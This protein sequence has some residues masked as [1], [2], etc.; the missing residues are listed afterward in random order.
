MYVYW[1]FSFLNIA[2]DELF[3][4]FCLS[5]LSGLGLRANQISF[6]LGGTTLVYFLLQYALLTG[7]VDRLGLYRTLRVGTFG[8]VPLAIWIPIG[9]LWL[10]SRMN[11]ND[12]KAFDEGGANGTEIQTT[13]TPL[14]VV[15]LCTLIA[16]MKSLSSVV[17]STVTIGTNRTVDTIDQRATL[18]G[19][20]SLGGSFAKACGPVFAGTLFSFTAGGGASRGAADD[21]DA[22]VNNHAIERPYGS[23][24][25]YAILSFLG[26]LLGVQTLFLR[27]S[28]S[29]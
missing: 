15:Y 28:K 7:L 9:S 17:F 22:F 21:A 4:L 29:S 20:G 23:I 12:D 27:G 19:I 26:V 1:M 10:A 11:T 18:N 2:T 14:V 25:S 24:V 16:I 13:L 3:P 6:I 5:K 8:S